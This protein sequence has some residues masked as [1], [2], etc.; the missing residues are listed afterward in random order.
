MDRFLERLRPSG[1]GKG[2]LFRQ[3]LFGN[4]VNVIDRLTEGPLTLNKVCRYCERTLTV[5]PVYNVESGCL[6]YTH[7]IL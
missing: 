4:I 3:Y 6:P 2:V 1:K 7:H 5:P